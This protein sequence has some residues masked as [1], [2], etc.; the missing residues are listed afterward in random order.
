MGWLVWVALA[1]LLTAVVA[2]T[3]IKSKG[4]RPVGN[5]RLMAAA[6]LILLVVIAVFV[7]MAFRVR[8]GG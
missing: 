6:R 1:V 7:Y 4:T 2:V 5:T 3:G 8:S